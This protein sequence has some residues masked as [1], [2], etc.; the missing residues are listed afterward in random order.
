MAGEKVFVVCWDEVWEGR[1]SAAGLGVR[2]GIRLE[3]QEMC[4]SAHLL[5]VALGGMACSDLF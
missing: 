1:F 3:G 2:L 5:L 4:G